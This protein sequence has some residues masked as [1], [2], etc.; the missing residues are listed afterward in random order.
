MAKKLPTLGNILI[1][2]AS[3]GI[4]EALARDYAEPGRFLALTGR[5]KDRLEDVAKACRTFGAEVEAKPVDV[6]RRDDLARWIADIDAH[7]PLD[8]VIA[9]AGTSSGSGG[10]GENED[11]ARDIFTVNLAG[12]LNTVWPAIAPMRERR[13]GQIAIISSVAAFRGLP[14][15]P[16]YA[17]S[18]AAVKVYG[19]GLRGWLAA[20]RIKVSVVCPGFV[21]TRM[22]ENNIYPMPFLMDADKAARIIRRGLERNKARIAFPWPM[23]AMAWFLGTLPPGWTDWVFKK[24]PRK[25]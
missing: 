4:G 13:R 8:L 7:H 1:T 11:Q 14:G 20:D 23:Y 9:N 21:R 2:G 6:T 25:D 10:R 3:S 17:A 5:D 19:E 24:M 16:A 15:A 12:V 18:K 22:T